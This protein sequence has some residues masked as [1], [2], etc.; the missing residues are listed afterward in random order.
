MN[1]VEPHIK[2]NLKRNYLFVLA[3]YHIIRKKSL[4]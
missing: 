1:T 3:E 4:F 2:M